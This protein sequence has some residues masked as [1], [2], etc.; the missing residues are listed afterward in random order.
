MR[1]LFLTPQLPYPPHQGTTIRNWGLIAQLAR[2]HQ[3]SLLSFGSGPV[4]APVQARC[5]AVITVPPPQRSANR[6]LID[7]LLG[8]ADLARRLWSPA[9]RDALS[10]W[11]AREQFDGVQI[12][13]LEMA[14]YRAVVRAHGLPIVFDAHNAEHVLQQRAQSAD[15]GRPGRRLAALYSRLQVP[16]LKDLER[17]LCR[18]V[19]GVSVVSSEDAAALAALAPGVRPVVVANGIELRAYDMPA[20]IA[21][22]PGRVVFTG[23]MDYRP[24]VDA[25]TWF[26]GDVWPTIR[27]QAPEATFWIVGQA[28]TPAVRA[29]GG[30]D[31]V[32]VTGAVDDTRPF[33]AGARVYVAPLR[34][35]GGT[36]F[37]LLE[38][39]ALRRP[40]VS[41]HIGAEGFPLQNG[42]DAL[43]ADGPQAFAD[44]VCRILCEPDLGDRLGAAGRALIAA[45]Y[46][47]AAIVPHLETLWKDI[48]TRRS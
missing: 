18:T 35:G 45:R 21:T 16:R 30:R 32:H 48:L 27:A 28:P 44:A 38:A 47:W 25:M 10:D 11:L 14:A 33:I 36:R 8:R 34:M 15:R 17:D 39:L 43:L 20:P 2:R 40:V 13:G 7:L 31:G 9:F 4:P 23:K 46:D 5:A 29:L 42:R 24:N 22:E 37:K 19:D 3:I 41:T 6:R 12:E 26:V 1:L